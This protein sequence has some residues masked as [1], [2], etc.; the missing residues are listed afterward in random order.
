MKTR[1]LIVDQMGVLASERKKYEELAKHDDLEIAVLVPSKWEFNFKVFEFEKSIAECGYNI[2][3]LPVFF[4]G[5]A[6]RSFYK[7]SLKKILAE[8]RPEIIHLYQEPYSFFA[9]QVTLARNL[10][11]PKA[12]I[13]FITWENIFFDRPPFFGSWLYNTI[14]KYVHRNSSASTP[15]TQGAQDALKRKG[16]NKTCYVM[17]WG[18]DLDRFKKQDA[19]DL[20]RSLGLTKNFVI[21]YVGRFVE[22]KG[23]LDLVKA[24][25]LLDRNNIDPDPAL[26]LIGGGPLKPQIEHLA[27]ENGLGERIVFVNSISN[28]EMARYINCM[29][30]LALPSRDSKLWREQLGKALL[31]AMACE[32]P[33][34]GSDSGEI[35]HV[36]GDT[37][38]VFRAGDPYDLKEKIKEIMADTNGLQSMKK[39]AKDRVHQI[40]SWRSIACALHDFYRSAAM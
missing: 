13:I 26:L 8:T 3:K 22:E 39:R 6:H 19:T 24:F 16:Y 21:G 18:I 33:V 27:A 31:E 11:C 30:L 2:V 25:S 17:K 35:P 34:V 4:P 7:S 36:I 5:F 38:K 29:D 40:Y 12:K 20:K 9:A 37:G 1:V 23:I 14:E 28:T 10:F 32:V 15:I